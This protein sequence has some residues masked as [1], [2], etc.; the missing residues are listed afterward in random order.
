MGFGPWP[1]PTQ[2]KVYAFGSSQLQQNIIGFPL[3]AR[4]KS[5]IE[6]EVVKDGVSR[7]PD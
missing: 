5:I 4:N 6:V 2:R 1:S 3:L 7:K